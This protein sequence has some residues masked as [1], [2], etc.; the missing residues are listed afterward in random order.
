VKENIL[1]IP[2]RRET[3]L[4]GPAI[5][6]LKALLGT[7]FSLSAAERDH[8]GHGESYHQTMPPDA[9]CFAE[10]TDEVAAIVK[11]CAAH[12]IKIIP[13]GAGTSLE[14]HVTAPRGGVC[15]DL[16]RMTRI[17]KTRPD[18]LDATVEAGV[19]RHQ[20]NSELRD[21][22]MFF[23]IDP[24]GESTLGGM[25]ATRA[26]GTNAVRYGTMRENVVNITA[27]MADG[28][29]IRTGGRARKSSAGYDL[30]RLLVGSEGT[31][32]IITELTVRLYG[33]PEVISAAICPFATVSD[34]V[35]VVVAMIQCGIPI[36]RVELLDG[37]TIEA[38]N[39]Y[40]GTDYRALPT[41]FLEFH[42]ASAAV[43]EQIAFV[44]GLAEDQGAVDFQTA[45]DAESRNRLWRA[46]HSVHYAIQ[47]A[48]PNARVW[49]TDVCV[50]ISQLAACIAETQL[51]VETAS[52]FIGMLGHVGDGNFHLGLAVNPESVEEL[53][54]AE[55]INDRVI[56]RAIA[57]EGTCTGEHGIGSGKIK[58]MDLEHGPAV[59]FM[60]AIKQALDPKGL[61][62]PGKVLPEV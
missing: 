51:D 24:G 13:F 45:N 29:I 30:T 17:I 49:S 61:L 37:R 3:V 44:R 42:G 57:R 40:S 32:G 27:V 5:A 46:R 1:L 55:A 26:S 20:L 31:L 23:P 35:A 54:E 22:G 28:T 38:A 39:R 41:L 7:R 59:G 50:P 19:T 47:S 12:D 8:H 9:V 33:V 21:T 11:L 25:A 53:A 18:D 60:R 4:P 58:F 48:R 14:G 16:G 43:A 10:T 15:I 56:R 2:T 52:F 6:G 34:A 36:A 62:N